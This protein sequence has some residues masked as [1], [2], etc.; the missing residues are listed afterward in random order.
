MSERPLFKSLQLEDNSVIEKFFNGIKESLSLKKKE[1]KEK[2]F[3][4]NNR[5]LDRKWK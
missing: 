4:K 1:R 5:E 2:E 3:L